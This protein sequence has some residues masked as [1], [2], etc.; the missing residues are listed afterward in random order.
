MSSE[1]SCQPENRAKVAVLSTAETAP[2]GGRVGDWSEGETTAGCPRADDPRGAVRL[3]STARAKARPLLQK[4]RFSLTG[5][6]REQGASTSV[7]VSV[8]QNNG[9]AERS[10]KLWYGSDPGGESSYT[11]M[12][13]GEH[14]RRESGLADIQHSFD[15]FIAGNPLLGPHRLSGLANGERRRKTTQSAAWDEWSDVGSS[16]FCRG[17][18]RPSFD[19]S[20]LETFLSSDYPLELGSAVAAPDRRRWSSSINASDGPADVVT[21][22][23]ALLR[24]YSEN[25]LAAE[26]FRHE[27]NRYLRRFTTMGTVTSGGKV[28]E[29]PSVAWT[30]AAEHA[31]EAAQ[32]EQDVPLTPE[33]LAAIPLGPSGELTS[34]GSI[35]HAE[36]LCRPCAFVNNPKREGCKNGIRCGYCHFLHVK[37]RVPRP[38]KHQRM[39]RRALRAQTEGAP[40]MASMV[41]L[42]LNEMVPYGPNP[43]TAQ[44]EPTQYPL[45]EQQGN[46]AAQLGY[47]KHYDQPSVPDSNSVVFDALVNAIALQVGAPERGP[48]SSSAVQQSPSAF[49]RDDYR[50]TPPRMAGRVAG[51][52]GAPGGAGTRGSAGVPPS[53]VYGKQ[54]GGGPK[55][56]ARE[57]KSTTATDRRQVGALNDA[58]GYPTTLSPTTPAY[59]LE[60]PPASYNWGPT[61]GD[62]WGG[63]AGQSP[64]VVRA[65][66]APPAVA[67][68]YPLQ[69]PPFS[70]PRFWMHSPYSNSGAVVS[71]PAS[72]TTPL[73]PVL[74]VL[75][76]VSPA[77]TPG[78]PVSTNNPYYARG[79]QRNNLRES[80]AERL[81]LPPSRSPF[82]PAASAVF[83]NEGTGGGRPPPLH[84]PRA[85]YRGSPTARTGRYDA[86][87]MPPQWR[88]AGRGGRGAGG[89]FPLY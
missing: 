54:G 89:G 4:T 48:A 66:G 81:P 62:G 84:H 60:T 52:G 19:V 64:S 17:A 2:S 82:P 50:D 9:V 47:P 18:Q 63:V 28:A 46:A 10:P 37:K 75:T 88:A 39:V 23:Q 61:G 44:V 58:V 6:G 85:P 3:D 74:Y 30:A 68:P 38:S 20:K 72:S 87:S 57:Q 41:P 70:V 27:V 15:N 45:L 33:Q 83:T 69:S 77:L 26:L 34:V 49:L 16:F 21:A 80:D 53:P 56:A 76:N 31:E 24:C 55:G 8:L 5:S 25:R 1:M 71:S 51:V 67:M 40:G 86:P 12:G 35:G 14:Q 42:Y 59:P 78:F 32:L 73:S 65:N 79:P 22:S 43:G 11:S 29:K 36:G 7:N 13:T